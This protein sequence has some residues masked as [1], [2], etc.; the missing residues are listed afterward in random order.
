MNLFDASVRRRIHQ[1]NRRSGS[2]SHVTP[3]IRRGLPRQKHHLPHLFGCWRASVD[4][5]PQLR[6]IA[7]DA[8]QHRSAGCHSGLRQLGVSGRH[9]PQSATYRQWIALTSHRPEP[10]AVAGRRRCIASHRHDLSRRVNDGCERWRHGSWITPPLATRELSPAGPPRLIDD[11]KL[12]CVPPVRGLNRS[13]CL[14]PVAKLAGA[15]R[16]CC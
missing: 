3:R 8:G 2:V 6:W 4:G 16:S 13:S 7:Q 1:A 12:N 11:R 9:L 14:L 5:W 10:V 15:S